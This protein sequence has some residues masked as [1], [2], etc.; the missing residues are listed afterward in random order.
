VSD[1]DQTI[2]THIASMLEIAVPLWVER[3]QRTSWLAVRDATPR[4]VLMIAEHGDVILY[5]SPTRGDTT[6]AFNAL[7]EAVAILSFAPGGV[8]VFGH[9]WE[10]QHPDLNPGA[11]ASTS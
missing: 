3:W 1:H 10:S 9:R 6:Q 8:R 5:R 7:A 4:L 11:L 2:A